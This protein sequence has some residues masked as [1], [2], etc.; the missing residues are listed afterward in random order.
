VWAGKSGR[1]EVMPLLVAR[2]ARVDADP[3][4]GTPLLWAAANGRVEAARWLLE[5]GADVNQRAS[6]GGASHG[7]GATALHLAAQ[8]DHVEVIDA[9]LARGA[10][11]TIR[12]ALYDSTPV[13]WAEHGSATRAM[14]ALQAWH[15]RY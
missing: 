15:E 9:L 5:H 12:D 7:E 2:G 6:F 14:T 1:T 3:Y 11:P 4:R 13:G 8:H 10:D